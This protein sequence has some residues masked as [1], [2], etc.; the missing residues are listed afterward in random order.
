MGTKGR[1]KAR[2]PRGKAA[3]DK[4]PAAPKAETTGLP[5]ALPPLGAAAIVFVAAGA[6]LVLEILAVRLLAPYVGLT[7]ET[8]TSIIGAALAGIAIGAALGG[9]I[10]DRTDTRRLIVGLLIGGGLLAILIVPLVHWLG[11]GARGDGDLAALGITVVA[12]VPA[13]A[14]LSAVSPAVA[15]LQLHDLRASGTV[16]GGLSG[17]ATAGA[18]L[19]TFGTGFVL[20]PLMPVGTAVLIT[21]VALVLA[22]IALAASSRLLSL[23]GITGAGLSVIVLGA[24]STSLDSPCDAETKYHCVTLEADPANPGGY[25]LLLDDL[26]H[27]Y[28]DL[29]DPT[30]L[31]FNYTRWIA[32]GIDAANPP[33]APLEVVFVG[34]GGFTLPRWLE[35]TRPGSHSEVLE[36][37]GELVEF[38]EEHLELRESEAIEISVGDA[39][40]GMLDVADDSADVVVGDAFGNLS[41]PWHLA[42][43]EWTDEVKRVLVPDGLYALNVI[44]LGPLDLQRAVA[45]TLLEDFAHLRMVTYGAEERPLGGNAVFLASDRPIPAGAA[46]NNKLATTL[47]P[48]EVERFAEDGEVLR[49][50]FAPADQLLTAN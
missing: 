23:L 32:K 47:R 41:V 4:A 21:G 17:W 37:D 10:A 43:A 49:D 27:S 25:V 7:L 45:A 31:G 11:P 16:V 1:A 13:A 39:R 42:T 36:V 26:S 5:K 28:V 33:K 6:V 9:R 14:V 3:A 24:W 29:N 38:D 40:I 12:L 50:E 44:D 15:H 34:G 22:G 2:K 35:A 30:H 18:L 19:G 48:S 8:T 20:V 46:T